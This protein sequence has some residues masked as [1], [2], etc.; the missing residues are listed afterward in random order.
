MAHHY[1][2]QQVVATTF[3]VLLTLTGCNSATLPTAPEIAPQAVTT[4]ANN[5]AIYPLS[6]AKGSAKYYKIAVPTGGTEL[7][8]AMSGGSGNADLYVRYNSTPTTS[9]YTCRPY[10]SGNAEKCYFKTPKA[11]SY[12][13]MVRGRSAYSNVK[14]LATYKTTTSPIAINPDPTTISS[15]YTVSLIFGASISE[16][17]KQV[18][19][20]AANRWRQ[21]IV[22]DEL[23]YYLSKPANACG[24]NE[25]AYE[26]MVDDIVVYVNATN[27]DGTGNTLG[28]SGPCALREE[29]FLPFYA[30]LTLD[31]ADM[32]N[33]LL[34]DIIYHE[35]GHALGFSSS[36]LK[37]KGLTSSCPTNDAFGGA[38]ASSE[39]EL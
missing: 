18:F 13:L 22:G 6:G 35:L 36:I 27:I 31:S 32:G 23:D 17:Q 10:L 14:L 15:N 5:K 7:T 20:N 2:R 9:T 33:A 1:F 28:R 38:A 29:D 21:V 37:A 26:G 25:P 34:Q 3:L 30:T 24:Q 39:G 16:A 4:L 8:V 12:Y 11:G 19:Y